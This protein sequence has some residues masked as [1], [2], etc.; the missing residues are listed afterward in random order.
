MEN[1][2]IS[3]CIPT[4]KRY[5]TLHDLIKS[6]EIGSLVPDSYYVIDNGINTE[7][8]SSEY[9]L[10][11]DISMRSKVHV[12]RFGCNIGVAKSWNWF[13]LNTPQTRII[14]N[15]DITFYNDTIEKISQ[16]GM[17]GKM[18]YAGGIANAFSCF[19]LPDAIIDTIGLFDETISPGYGYFEDNDYYYRMTLAGFGI[20]Q[21]ENTTIGHVGSATLKSLSQDELD[22]HHKKFQLARHNYMSK[23]GGPPGH[24]LFK[25]PYNRR[26]Q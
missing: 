7:F 15:D 25:I 16:I 18:M 17:D 21:L 26:Q 23:W 24:E 12:Y 14:C 11:L 8:T 6:A 13:I 3:V 9:Y 2:V 4:L 10:S 5:D 1:K 19:V 22:A 20:E